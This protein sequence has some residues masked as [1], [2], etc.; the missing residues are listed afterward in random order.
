MPQSWGILARNTGRYRD[1]IAAACRRALDTCACCEVGRIIKTEDRFSSFASFSE[2]S[3]KNFSDFLRGITAT[4]ASVKTRVRTKSAL[5]GGNSSGSKAWN[6]GMSGNAR[7]PRERVIN[8]YAQRQVVTNDQFGCFPKM[9]GK[10]AGF[11]AAALIFAAY[12]VWFWSRVF[13]W[14][15]ALIHG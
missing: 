9:G 10:A 5:T 12:L 4:N 13:A 15:G 1:H 7:S 2:T 3:R 6:S 14:L 8:D 11:L